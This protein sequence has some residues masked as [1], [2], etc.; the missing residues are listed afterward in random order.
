MTTRK[1][2]RR[3]PLDTLEPVD[4]EIISGLRYQDDGKFRYFLVA[5]KDPAL[6]HDEL[7]DY[8][9]KNHAKIEVTP[10]LTNESI[11][12]GRDNSPLSQLLALTKKHAVKTLATKTP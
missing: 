10:V 1:K 6:S 11:G 9:K 2:T 4:I 5:H 3:K 7:D 12:V 8:L